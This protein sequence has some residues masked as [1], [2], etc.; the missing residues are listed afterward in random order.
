MYWQLMDSGVEGHSLP[1]VV[2]QVL[3][4]PDSKRW[5]P[6][7]GHIDCS[8]KSRW[9]QNK[10]KHMNVAKVPPRRT[11]EGHRSGRE[12]KEVEVREKEWAIHVW[13]C[14]R[15]KLMKNKFQKERRKYIFIF[16]CQIYSL[17]SWWPGLV[18]NSHCVLQESVMKSWEVKMEVRIPKLEPQPCRC[19]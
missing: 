8:G 19:L 7:C 4:P 11:V 1:S 5:F 16:F 9:L 6:P 14:Q 17:K 3:S 2:C 18:V 13:S 12:T 15:M 10:R